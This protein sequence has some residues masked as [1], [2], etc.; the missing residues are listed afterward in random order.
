MKKECFNC[1]FKERI[2]SFGHPM[3]KCQ[4]TGEEFVLTECPHEENKVIMFRGKRV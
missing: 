2:A 3:F 1:E 4:I